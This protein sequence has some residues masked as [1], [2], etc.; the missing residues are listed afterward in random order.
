MSDESGLFTINPLDMRKI[1]ADLG[2][3]LRVSKS[4]I[5]DA[6]ILDLMAMSAGPINLNGLIIGCYKKYNVKHKRNKITARVYRL[7]K[8]GLVH[9]VGKGVYKIGGVK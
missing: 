3:E 6:Q 8:R 1:P 9:S 2:K 5:E 7:I 4:D